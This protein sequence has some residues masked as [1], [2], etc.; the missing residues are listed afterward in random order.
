M[1]AV[2]I[3]ACV[4]IFVGALGAVAHLDAL[5]PEDSARLE[6]ARNIFIMAAGAIAFP[7][8][9]YGLHMRKSSLDLQREGAPKSPDEGDIG[10]EGTRPSQVG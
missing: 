4:C 7:M 3:A 10:E 8:A 2:V 5:I 9:L 6:D 1:F